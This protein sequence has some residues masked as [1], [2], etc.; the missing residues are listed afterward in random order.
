MGIGSPNLSGCFLFL[1]L[2]FVKA[3]LAQVVGALLLMGLQKPHLGVKVPHLC[4][5]VVGLIEILSPPML[6]QFSNCP[7]LVS[8]FGFRSPEYSVNPC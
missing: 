7:R 1:V 4:A 8:Q 6:V 2:I 3:L 5:E